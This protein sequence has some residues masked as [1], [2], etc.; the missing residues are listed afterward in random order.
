MHS[1]RGSNWGSPVVGSL[2]GEHLAIHTAALI[3][4]A[5]TNALLPSSC[6]CIGVD[7]MASVCTLLCWLKILLLEKAKTHTQHIP[8]VHGSGAIG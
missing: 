2:V 8:F 5:S 7:N 3:D 4:V 6:D 1:P